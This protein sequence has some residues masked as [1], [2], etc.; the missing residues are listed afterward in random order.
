MANEKA[1]ITNR[2]KAPFRYDI[3][4]SF[5]RPASIKVARS[6]RAEGRIDDAELKG[7]ENEA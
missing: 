4:G 7:V 3:V 6:A 2:E 5:L 1:G